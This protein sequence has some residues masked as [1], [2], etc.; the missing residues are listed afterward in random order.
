MDNWSI[1]VVEDE[2]DGQEVVS[3]ILRYHNLSVD[4]AGDAESALDL[5]NQQRYALAIIDLSLPGLS[6]WEL[7]NIIRNSGSDMPCVAVTAYHSS[8]VAVKAIQ[9]GF[10]AYF[11]KP[12]DPTSFVR[13]LEYYFS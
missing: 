12:L 5:L 9:A 13:Q 1:L 8:D 2:P 3:S 4:V 6:G 10:K 11:P 7:L